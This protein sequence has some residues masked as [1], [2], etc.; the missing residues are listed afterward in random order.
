MRTQV[1]R[2]WI[3]LA[4]AALLGACSDKQI[5]ETAQGNHALECQKFPDTRYEECMRTVEQSYKDYQQ[6][7]EADAQAAAD[8]YE[9]RRSEPQV[10]GSEP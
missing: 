5:Y 10:D 1:A 9:R 4:A 3:L 6:T 7:R 2:L 8:E